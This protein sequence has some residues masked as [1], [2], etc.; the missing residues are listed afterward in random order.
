MDSSS[1]LRE[2]HD[3]VQD[4][5]GAVERPTERANVKVQP[6]NQKKNVDKKHCW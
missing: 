1:L 4:E 6:E 3:D 2:A 5:R